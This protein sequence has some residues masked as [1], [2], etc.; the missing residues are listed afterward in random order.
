MEGKNSNRPIYFL[1]KRCL[2]IVGSLIGLLFF[3]LFIPVLA[4]AIKLNSRGPIFFIQ[5]RVGQYGRKFKFVKYRT[6][7]VDAHQKQWELDNFNET[8]GLTFKMSKDPRVTTLGYWLRRT[9]LDETPQFW[10][11]LKGEMSLV[12]P[13]P[14]LLGEVERYTEQQKLRM[15]VPQG[16]TGLWQIRGR[17]AIPFEK[18]SDLD[19]YYALNA[20]LGLDL[21]ILWKTF[22]VVIF[23]RGAK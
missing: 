20:N 10:N 23:G 15:T 12:G 11:V 17:S 3:F 18:M 9:S 5:T 8:G 14:P 19:S 13:R 6:M 21:I 16:M 4:F 7:I 1:S 22:P 2:D